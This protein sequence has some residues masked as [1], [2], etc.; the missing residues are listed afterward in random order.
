[1]ACR[2]GEGVG[3]TTIRRPR[4]QGGAHEPPAGWRRRRS[5]WA[6]PDPIGA[7]QRS[8]DVLSGRRL[9]RRSSTPLRLSRPSL[10]STRS[11]LASASVFRRP[12]A[13]TGR[14]GGR[15]FS[16]SLFWA[17]ASSRA[18][19]VRPR[20]RRRPPLLVPPL[21][22]SLIPLPLHVRSGAGPTAPWTARAN[23][24]RRLW[25]CTVPRRFGGPTPMGAVA[26]RR[27][28]R[29]DQEGEADRIGQEAGR[30]QE[31]AGQK[32]NRQATSN[33]GRI[34][35]L[36]R[37]FSSRSGRRLTAFKKAPGA[38]SR[39]APMTAVRTIAASVGHRPIQPPTW[40]NR[41]DFDEAAPR[42]GP[43][44]GTGMAAVFPCPGGGP[45]PI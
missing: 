17:S 33:T 9:F 35:A 6:T 38:R 44:G 11:A 8:D 19:A 1:M 4:Q 40:M 34:S 3:V 20:P 30:Q 13:G 43:G 28:H 16:I 37:G 23:P 36:R 21:P 18:A 7:A 24:V 12:Q 15:V 29:R 26:D 41:T 31:G 27:P 25:T 5:P 2:H 45:G 39:A 22:P 14:A 42:S 32:K 10:R